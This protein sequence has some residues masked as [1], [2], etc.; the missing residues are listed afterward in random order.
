M[1]KAEADLHSRM[2]EIDFCSEYGTTIVTTPTNQSELR[3]I[4]L[5]SV[6]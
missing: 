6:V 1:Q 3:L 4:G 5:H 2:L